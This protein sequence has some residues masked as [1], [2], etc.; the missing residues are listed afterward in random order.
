MNSVKRIHILDTPID[1]LTMEETLAVIDEAIIKGRLV[2]HACLNAAVLVSMQKDPQLRKSVSSCEIINADGKSVVWASRFLGKP[3][4]E[5]V[6]GPDLMNRV[7][8]MAYR[9][10]YRIFF[11][12]ARPEVVEKV[13]AEYS[14]R[15]H[16]EIIAGFHHGYFSRED[17]AELVNTIGASKAQILFV[18]MTS[19][20]KE[21]FL[22]HYKEML[23]IP[24]IMG[25]GGAFDIVAG[26]IKRA[27]QWMQRSGLE[28]FYRLLQ[29]P[30]RMWKRYLITNSL[31]IFGVI[32]EKFTLS[33]TKRI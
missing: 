26:L 7:V 27:P 2:R 21:I 31:F 11:L 5:R 15:Y 32:K 30:G 25:V 13:V 12:G 33:R 6:A 14:S 22:D 10:R 4:P 1:A 9:K 8:E 20:K 18:A 28:W 19:P 29:E 23:Q 17:E 3:L 16:S 24:F